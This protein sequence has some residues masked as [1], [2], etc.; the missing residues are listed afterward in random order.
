MKALEKDRSRRYETVNGFAAD[1]Q[2]YLAGEAVQAHPPSAAYRLRKFARKHRVALTTV[3]AFTGL[4]IA[5]AVVSSWLAVKAQQAEALANEKRIEADEYATE[6]GYNAGRLAAA[7][8]HAQWTAASLQVDLDLTEMRSDPRSGVLRLARTLKSLPDKNPFTDEGL[9]E[10]VTAAALAKGQEFAS[11]L[12]PIAHDGQ[13]MVPIGLSPNKQMLLTLGKDFTARL[14]DTRTGKLIAILRQGDERVVNCGFSLDGRTAFTDDQTSVARFWDVPNGRFR[15]ATEARPNR[16]NLPI[17]GSPFVGESGVASYAR[18]A[19][20][21]GRD[22]LLTR[23]LFAKQG[24]EDALPQISWKGPVEM[25]ET[26]TGRLVG[27]LDEPGTNVARSCFLGDGKWIATFEDNTVLVYAAENGRLLARLVHPAGEVVGHV[28]LSP[29]GRRVFTVTQTVRAWDTGSWQAEPGVDANIGFPYSV[30]S[31][32]VVLTD[33]L[34]SR[35]HWDYDSLVGRYVFRLGQPGPIFEAHINPGWNEP[36][37]ECLAPGKELVRVNGDVYDTRTW[38]RLLPPPGQQFH[39][40]LAKF[41]AD[42]RFVLTTLKGDYVI[43]DTRTD[44]HFPV[45]GGHWD[46]VPGWSSLPGFGLILIALRQPWGG[47][48]IG[49]EVAFQAAG[50]SAEIRLL[51]SAERLSIP[52]ELLE[53]WAQVAVRGELDAEGRFAKWNEETWER[54]R[55]ELAAKPAPYPDFPF[56]GYVATDKLHWLRAEF[57]EAKTDTDKLRIARELLRRCEVA[58]DWVEAVRWREA[59]AQRAPKSAPTPQPV[60]P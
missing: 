26:S 12:P 17:D 46:S 55:Q 19:A 38:L 51:P 21:I 2:R 36:N 30:P 20:A 3:A 7:L 41:A 31:D 50:P 40:D 35:Q 37:L 47:V 56:P 16:Y 24:K 48:W 18:S 28:A 53:L 14:W 13:P 8:E 39:P 32:L 57:G 43:I 45:E 58:G 9:A 27:R 52:P 4:L 33:D 1:V 54:K 6:A 42:G 22:R 25:W 10:F 11:L 60:K 29:S 49:G 59:V 34:V 5:G 15:L 44:K 23:Q